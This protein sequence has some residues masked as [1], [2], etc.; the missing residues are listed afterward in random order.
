MILQSLAE[1]LSVVLCLSC[2]L[3]ST[4]L[5]LVTEATITRLPVIEEKR[6]ILRLGSRAHFKK[7][8]LKGII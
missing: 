5:L 6:E 3:T 2:I 7:F 4:L 8:L 1:L